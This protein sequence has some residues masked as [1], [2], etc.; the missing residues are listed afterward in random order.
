MAKLLNVVIVYVFQSLWLYRRFLSLCWIKHFAVHMGGA[1][2][3]L[4]L[5]S[6][7]L[8]FRLS[9]TIPD[10]VFEDYESQAMFAATYVM[11]LIKVIWIFFNFRYG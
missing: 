7:L 9:T 11:W 10:N 2:I 6:E 1:H 5:D 4:F 8:L 3:D